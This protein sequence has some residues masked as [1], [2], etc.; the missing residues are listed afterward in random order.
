M[1][2]KFLFGLS[3]DLFNFCEVILSSRIY[4]WQNLDFAHK[5]A[6]LFWAGVA[7]IFYIIIYN[8]LLFIAI[9]SFPIVKNACMN[10]YYKAKNKKSN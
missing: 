6:H 1:S 8:L 2:D 3:V 4:N 5:S 10:S 7:V 9:K